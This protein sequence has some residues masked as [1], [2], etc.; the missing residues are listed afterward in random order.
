[1]RYFYALVKYTKYV[2]KTYK[3]NVTVP[4]EQKIQKN[5][6]H[7]AW[8][9][10]NEN[11]EDHDILDKN[12]PAPEKVVKNIENNDLNQEI[13]AVQALVKTGLAKNKNDGKAPVLD[14]DESVIQQV[15]D[16]KISDMTPVMGD[17]MASR[18]KYF[19]DNVDLDH[20]DIQHI[21]RDGFQPDSKFNGILR[22]MMAFTMLP[23]L[24]DMPLVSNILRES[25]VKEKSTKD[26][27]V[28]V[29]KPHIRTLRT[30]ES[31][32]EARSKKTF[33]EIPIKEWM[34]K[35]RD[36]SQYPNGFSLFVRF[37]ESHTEEI[38]LNE[39]RAASMI[40][41]GLTALA[42][43][44]KKRNELINAFVGE[45]YSAFIKIKML[46]A[47]IILAKIHGA[48]FREEYSNIFY[49]RKMFAKS[50]FWLEPQTVYAATVMDAN[51][52][53]AKDEVGEPLKQRKITVKECMLPD[54]FMLKPRAYPIHEF[55]VPCPDHVRES[56]DL[57]EAHPDMSDKAMFDQ[58]WVVVPGIALA[59]E[60]NEYTMQNGKVWVV[61]KPDKTAEIYQSASDAERSLDF[62]L[63]ADGLLCPVVLGE[64]DGK[65]YFLTYWN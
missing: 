31:R 27:R 58:F 37:N 6:P 17:F 8:N 4:D 26:I 14:R 32:E 35:T 30:K 64:K 40:D 55:K 48:I 41:H 45:N 54:T 39:L 62:R 18:L 7:M 25:F 38:K 34:E 42:A 23:N 2:V 29:Y 9:G 20:P 11:H 61:A 63:T 13:I 52:E 16:G 46:D 3:E 44:F 56:L 65:C 22:E 49:P 50:C 28:T 60:M 10:N 21:I 51:L 59:A 33:K 53:I 24:K 1:M 57:V 43:S 36:P 15:R 47:A 12:I 5:Q 19:C